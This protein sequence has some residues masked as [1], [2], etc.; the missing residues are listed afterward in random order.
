MT[1]A[2]PYDPAK[3]PEGSTV[4]IANRAALEEFLR[5]WQWHHKLQ[6]NQVEHAGKL[7]KVAKSFMYHGGDVIYVLE[8]VPGVWHE[9]CLE[10]ER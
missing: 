5:T 1:V 2:T 4:R 6:P 9:Q 8:H 7:A 10:D 3:Y